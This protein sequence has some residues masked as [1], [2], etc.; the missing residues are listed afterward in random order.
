MTEEI[1]SFYKKDKTS[2]TVQALSSPPAQCW[3]H[4]QTSAGKHPIPF[5]FGMVISTVCIS[6]LRD[7]D[8]TNYNAAYHPIMKVNSQEDVP[9]WRVDFKVH[10]IPDIAI[11]PKYKQK[12]NTVSKIGRADSDWRL[13][14]V[15]DFFS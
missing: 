6:S 1:S 7:Q 13:I 4:K 5:Y 2:T 15:T 3:S 12:R 10:T 9:D 8:L 14:N 11:I